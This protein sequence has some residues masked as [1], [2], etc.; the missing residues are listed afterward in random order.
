MGDEYLHNGWFGMI[1]LTV[2]KKADLQL[3]LFFADLSKLKTNQIMKRLY[4]IIFF[5][6]LMAAPA[7]HHEAE[8]QRSKR[9]RVV[10]KRK[11]KTRKKARRQVSRRAHLPYASLTRYGAR[12]VTVP[13]GA[14]VIKKSNKV[15]NYHKGIF[16]SP[17]GSEF[18]VVRPE[19]GIRVR[20]L[21][22]TR[23]VLNVPG[24]NLHYY[25]GTFYAEVGEE[26]EVIQAPEGAIVDALP[27]GYEVQEIEETEYYV[28][29]DIYYREVDAEAFD[30]GKG[31]EVVKIG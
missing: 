17:T 29:D 12:I 25:Y 30:S 6:F 26:Y 2:D 14:I 23:V 18:V 16:Y 7:V 1:G 5:A 13:A 27:E 20:T 3:N 9:E 31:Y 19:R 11:V 24:R 10:K 22:S 8:A 21:P 15:Y 4:I 28:W